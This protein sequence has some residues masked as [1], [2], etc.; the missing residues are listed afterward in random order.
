MG[1]AKHE[2]IKRV[3]GSGILSYLS[4]AKGR[5]P[6]HWKYMFSKKLSSVPTRPVAGEALKRHLLGGEARRGGGQED[7]NT[8]GRGKGKSGHDGT[9]DFWASFGCRMG[10]LRHNGHEPAVQAPY[11]PLKP[12]EYEQHQRRE[13]PSG[14][15]L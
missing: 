8:R 7:N 3:M 1:S 14:G 10:K 15:I 6:R 4:L 13:Q 2:E 9:S 12:Q 5:M 11:L